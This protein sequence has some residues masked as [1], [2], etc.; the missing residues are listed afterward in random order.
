[1]IEAPLDGPPARA[2]EQRIGPQ[3]QHPPVP[4]ARIGGRRGPL[5]YRSVGRVGAR[6]RRRPNPVLLEQRADLVPRR[7]PPHA[8]L[9]QRALRREPSAAYAVPTS[10]VSAPRVMRTCAGAG[11]SCGSSSSSATTTVCWRLPAPRGVISVDARVVDHALVHAHQARRHLAR[12]EREHGHAAVERRRAAGQL[13]RRLAASRQ[14]GVEHESPR[15]P[16]AG[17][18]TVSR[19]ETVAR[20]IAAIAIS[21]RIPYVYGVIT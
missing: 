10:Q 6:R 9:L 20:S 17:V 19:V 4:A 13:A 3:R 21:C 1:M 7:R 16:H 11:K 15:A 12:R 14:A 5:R 8:A 2:A 18:C